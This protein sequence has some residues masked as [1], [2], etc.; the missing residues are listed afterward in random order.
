[1]ISAPDSFSQINKNSKN[2]LNTLKRIK[3]RS[4]KNI[5][6]LKLRSFVVISLLLSVVF[7]GGYFLFRFLNRS[8]DQALASQIDN[9]LL[10]NTFGE[11]GAI[12]L[13]TISNSQAKIV[14]TK[15]TKEGFLVNLLQSES[16]SNVGVYKTLENGE[17]DNN[18][19]E[20]GLVSFDF[21]DLKAV[22]LDTDS[23]FVYVLASVDSC[24]IE[25]SNSRC[26]GIDLLLSKRSLNTGVVDNNFGENGYLRTNLS[27]SLNLSKISQRAET[28]VKIKVLTSGEIVILSDYYYQS[29]GDFKIGVAV[30]K[31]DENGKPAKDFGTG[32]VFYINQTIF[33]NFIKTTSELKPRDLNIQNRNNISIQFQT[34]PT[35]YAEINIDVNGK[36]IK[37]SVNNQD[38]YLL[39]PDFE[40]REFL[41]KQ[42]LS[43]KNKTGGV[44][45]FGVCES[46]NNFE[47]V[48]CLLVYNSAG[49]L[50]SSFASENKNIFIT[51]FP[52]GSDIQFDPILEDLDS[53]QILINLS[54]SRQNGGEIIN[55]MLLIKQNGKP[56]TNFANLGKWRRGGKLQATLIDSKGRFLVVENQN[57]YRLQKPLFIDPVITQ[58]QPE[59]GSI[60]GGLEVTLTGDNFIKN[61][62]NPKITSIQKI[63]LGNNQN[64]A[65]DNLDQAF[66]KEGNLILIGSFRS[67]LKIDS[68]T[69][70]SEKDFADSFVAKISKEN[71]VIW[72][73]VIG[74][75]SGDDLV[76]KL[77]LDS[78]GDILVLLESLSELN[79]LNEL[80]PENLGKNNLS[81]LKYK[82]DG[83]L[84]WVA[85]IS[86]SN[87]IQP[88]NEIYENNQSYILAGD[89]K[90][91]INSS[92]GTLN[93][94]LQTSFVANINKATGNTNWLKDTPSD[95]FSRISK[96]YLSG[97]DILIWGE[98][99]GKVL[100]QP[101]IGGKDLFYTKMDQQGSFLETKILGGGGEDSI[102]D[103]VFDKTKKT[104]YISGFVGTESSFITA[105]D[106]DAKPIWR[107]LGGGKIVLDNEGS[108]VLTGNFQKEFQID[109]QTLK[110]SE[111][112]SVFVAK[113]SPSGQLLWLK[114]FLGS[115]QNSLTQIKISKSNEI[116]ITSSFTGT[117]NIEQKILTAIGQD[118]YLA[119]ISATGDLIWLKQSGGKGV[120]KLNFVQS[121]S[122]SE[123]SLVLKSTQNSF[124]DN[125]KVE[126]EDFAQAVVINLEEKD[127]QVFLGGIPVTSFKVIN[128]NKMVIV[129]PRSEQG[130]KDLK[131]VGYDGSETVFSNAFEYVTGVQI[132]S[133]DDVSKP[134][135]P[136]KSPIII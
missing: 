128:Q 32:G 100:D 89:Y 56:N 36:I 76:K 124:F 131:V 115:S 46:K 18:F 38:V 66:D 11:N 102:E 71:K 129:T 7:G 122:N 28:P 20:N 52:Q 90:S 79:Y 97:Q 82:P 30:A 121:D 77:F 65:I 111:G 110:N 105:F 4:N 134:S 13:P 59:S 5:F 26:S 17:A 67:S 116:Y 31:Y 103:L 83:V 3:P 61:P 47:E 74:G 88:L 8:L 58:V 80:K 48:F 25:T 94:T 2:Q 101:G 23:E 45:F 68:Q 6:G 86:S 75:K 85:N 21:P 10:D 64:S 39:N 40:S 72:L 118:S 106:F 98:F 136:T 135:S 54:F 130:K 99:S 125:Q 87:K 104:F 37:S 73:N 120:S 114:E 35:D 63:L 132:K 107:I 49:K 69:A 22:D 15:E 34:N 96:I 53:G 109:N 33:P 123:I 119:K 84:S 1:M 19:G 51:N 117:S 60:E 93:N 92:L 95:N 29:G 43:K 78:N 62:E 44:I 42:I 70:I 81:L 91:D 55:E 127:I 50:D 12:S 9:S 57:I 27:E 113:V 133:G 126:N 108:L 16:S 14:A 24:K 41:P 112:S